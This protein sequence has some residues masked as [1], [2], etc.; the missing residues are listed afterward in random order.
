MT[1]LQKH[2]HEIGACP[3]ARRWAGDRT[4]EQ[5]WSESLRADWLLWWAGRCGVDRKLLVQ[6]ACQ[7]ARR[8]LRFAPEGEL[9]PLRAI[10]AAEAWIANPCAETARAAGAAA[11][12]AEA[13]AAW[14]VPAWA[15]PAWPEA[16]WAAEHRDMCDNVRSIISFE[17]LGLAKGVA[18]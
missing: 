18:A 9:R 4:F 7:C 10:E 8:A 17:L 16:A 12:A 15:V 6:C 2:L 1:E 11:A 5:A 13:A 3:E 14:A